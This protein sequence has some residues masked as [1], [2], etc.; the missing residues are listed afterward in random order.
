M[1]WAE[2]EKGAILA[3]MKKHKGDV[4][5]AAKELGIGKTSIYRKY[6]EYG[7]RTPRRQGIKNSRW[8]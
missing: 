4:Y 5:L 6:R 2:I 7:M 1:T 8:L 3:A